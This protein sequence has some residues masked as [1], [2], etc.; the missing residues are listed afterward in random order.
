[1]SDRMNYIW[2]VM[3][4]RGEILFIIGGLVLGGLLGYLYNNHVRLDDQSLA[5]LLYTSPSPR[6]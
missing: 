1:M 2:K 6:D 3:R 5:C 4:N